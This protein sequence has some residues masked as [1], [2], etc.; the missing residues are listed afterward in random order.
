MDIEK[1]V[2]K[3]LSRE[4]IKKLFPIY[5][6]QRFKGCGKLF[7]ENK[8]CAKRPGIKVMSKK[9]TMQFILKSM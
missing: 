2:P 7:C 5:F 4:Q 3:K 1:K 8:W 6:N 9:E